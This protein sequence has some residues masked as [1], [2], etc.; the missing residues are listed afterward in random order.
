MKLGT[1]VQFKALNIF[2]YEAVAKMSCSSHGSHFT[3]SPKLNYV[4]CVISPEFNMITQKGDVYPDVL[5]VKGYND[6]VYIMNYSGERL[7]SATL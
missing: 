2:T 5:M 1:V 6:T 3:F 7:N 4:F